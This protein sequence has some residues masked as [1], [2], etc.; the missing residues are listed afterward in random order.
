MQILSAFA[1]SYFVPVWIA[2]MVSARLGLEVEKSP[3]THA[4]EWIANAGLNTPSCI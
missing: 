3:I 4:N 1:Y 2:D